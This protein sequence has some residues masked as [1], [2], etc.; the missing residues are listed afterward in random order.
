MAPQMLTNTLRAMELKDR[1]T[2]A[3]IPQPS[4]IQSGHT[5]FTISKLCNVRLLSNEIL[6]A[7][8][9]SLQSYPA[10][11]K[12]DEDNIWEQGCEVDHLQEKNIPGELP[13]HHIVPGLLGRP[14]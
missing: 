14:N 12:N 7:I 5:H 8:S 10:D 3:A 11:K 6:N 13:L 4:I 2:H 1:H 9:S